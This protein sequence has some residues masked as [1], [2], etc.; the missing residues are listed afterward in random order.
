MV[1][2]PSQAPVGLP[3]ASRGKEGTMRLWT[4]GGRLGGGGSG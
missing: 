4:P 3:L 1:K 2:L